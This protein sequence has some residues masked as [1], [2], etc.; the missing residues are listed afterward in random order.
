MLGIMLARPVSSVVTDLNHGRRFFVT[1]AV[2]MA[3]LFVASLGGKI[4]QREQWKRRVAR[5]VANSAIPMRRKPFD[6][7][8]ITSGPFTSSRITNNGRVRTILSSKSHHRA[9]PFRSSE[10]GAPRAKWPAEARTPAAVTVFVELGGPGMTGQ[11][12]S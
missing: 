2:L 3:A 10:A 12:R 7:M 5:P 9:S 8:P 6:V 4:Q 1:F 11:S